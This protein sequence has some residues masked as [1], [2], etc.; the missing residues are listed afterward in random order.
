MF[1][2]NIK[3]PAIKKLL[4][5][6]ASGIGAIAGPMLAK[7]KA[8]IEADAQRTKAQG[9]A[10]SIQLITDAKIEARE[11]FKKLGVASLSIQSELEIGEQIQ[12]RIAF[13]EE[14]R[15]RNIKAVISMAAEEIK[16]KEVQD[17]EI[18]HDWTARFFSDVQDV[19]SEQMQ[20]VWAK[21]LAGE[22]ETPG[23]T[24]LHTLAILKNM[25]QKD[26]ELFSKVAQFVINSFVFRHGATKKVDGFPNAGMIIQLESYGLI[27]SGALLSTNLSRSYTFAD[28]SRVYHILQENRETSDSRVVGVPC[29]ILTSA[30]KEL[31]QF[32]EVQ[33]NMDYLSV[34]ANFLKEQ[35]AKLEYAPIVSED[36]DEV[37]FKEPWTQVQP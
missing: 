9:V 3:V 25:T 34:F 36:G 6:C 33:Q 15:Q 2:V 19:S 11:K 17:H 5:H 12:A 29:H 7:W 21:I 24:S 22:V 35:N 1:D 27:H 28:K 30:G 4:D 32:V 10:D 31:Y 23:R 18:D 16:D 26:A 13:Q 8:Q 37:T 14:K 20:I